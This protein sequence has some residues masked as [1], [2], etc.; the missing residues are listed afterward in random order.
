[1]TTIIHQAADL[2]E[3]CPELEL[4]VF[5]DRDVSEDPSAVEEALKTVDA[6]FASL[7]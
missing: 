2:A 6:F 5:T 4:V 1:S 3:A 7:V